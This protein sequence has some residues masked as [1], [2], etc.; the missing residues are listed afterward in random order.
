MGLIIS[1]RIAIAAV[2]ILFLVLRS[3][4]D[5]INNDKT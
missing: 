1:F 2:V 3:Y 5:S 4:I